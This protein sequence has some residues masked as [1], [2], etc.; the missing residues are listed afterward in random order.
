MGKTMIK[1]GDL[2]ISRMPGQ[3]RLKIGDVSFGK[4]G[5]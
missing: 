2:S 4:N 3:A 5:R 1:L